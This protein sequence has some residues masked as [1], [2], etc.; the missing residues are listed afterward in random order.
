MRPPTRDCE[1]C[2]WWRVTWRS[3]WCARPGGHAEHR[4]SN[5][6]RCEDQ[7]PRRG[8]DWSALMRSNG[9]IRWRE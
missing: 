5:E 9:D 8:E 3:A 7:E 1:E 2:R 6:W 4:H